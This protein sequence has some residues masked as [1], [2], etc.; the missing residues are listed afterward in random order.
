MPPPSVPEPGTVVAYKFR[1][2]LI[3]PDG[4]VDGPTIAV[5]RPALVTS[6]NTDDTLNLMVF[7]NWYDDH[8]IEDDHGHWWPGIL[9]VVKVVFGTD[10]LQWQELGDIN[11]DDFKI[12]PDTIDPAP[13]SDIVPAP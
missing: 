10:P 7:Q 8:G 4:P 12:D 9:P 2:D 6:V 3:D 5:W 1:D 13:P 11:W